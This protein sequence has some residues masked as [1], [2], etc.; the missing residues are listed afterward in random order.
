MDQAMIEQVRRFNRTVTQRIGALDDAFLARDRPLG[1]ARLLWEIRRDGSDVRRLRSR[2]DLDSGYLSRLL[3][4]LERDGLIVVEPS[5]A[6]G[7]VRTA[8]LTSEGRAEQAELDRRSDDA[9]AAL[10]KPLSARQR[11]RL[12]AAMAEVERLLVASAVQIGGC[13]PRRPEARCAVQAYLAELAQRFEEGFDPARGISA[14]DEEVSP[15]AG[16]FLL[17]TLHGEPVGCGV[18][19]F[20]HPASAHIKR[21][22]VAEAVRGLGL[23]RRL[24]AELETHAAAHGVRTVQ[25]ETHHALAEAI[26]LY[27]TAGYREVAAFNEEPYARHWFEK[28]I[29]AL[30]GTCLAGRVLQPVPVAGPPRLVP[31][32][33]VAVVGPD[34]GRPVDELADDVGVTGVPVGL[35]DHVHQD[36][37]QRDLAAPLPPPRHVAGRVQGQRGDRGVRVRP[38]PAIEPGDVAARLLGGGP[39]V[40]V[41]LG[42]FLQPWQRL[43]EGLAEHLAEIP[44]LHAGQVLDQAE[45]VGAGRH[46]RAADVVLGQPVELPQHRLAGGLQVAAKVCL[47]I[48][49]GHARQSAKV[50]PSGTSGAD[51]D[52]MAEVPTWARD[53]LAGVFDP[54]CQEKGI[55]V[56]DMGL[57]RSVEVQDG[58]ARVE[59]LLTSGWCPFAATVLTQVEDQIRRAPGIRRADVS[60]VWDEAWTTDR[61]SPRARSILRFLPPPSAVPDRD[62][63]IAAHLKEQ[64]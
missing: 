4:S 13:D 42:A 24:L 10:L 15:P 30:A 19:K 37:V 3:R 43:V 34:P 18:L 53:A 55:S 63:Y 58:V 17:A 47:G 8:H 38:R 12:M 40:R 56:I 33:E 57:V 29:G 49:I 6:D 1:Q 60:I 11:D 54:C 28:T 31:R 25:L 44:E 62:A 48:R 21:M 41:G 22:W 32:R 7:R 52:D 20:H 45:Q 23:G 2:L 39:H 50:L 64:Q 59:L 35:G 26:S 36:L 27:R 46:H 5:D 61:L 16:L 9:A 51:D 14:T